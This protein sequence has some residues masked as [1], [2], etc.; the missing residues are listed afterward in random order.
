MAHYVAFLRGI[1][2]GGHKPVKMEE[3]CAL[4][5]SLGFSGVRTHIQSGNVFFDSSQKDEDALASVIRKKISKALGYDAA[6]FVRSVGSLRALLKNNP[7]R[8]VET[9]NDAKPYITFI[10]EKPPTGMKLPLFSPNKDVEIFAM[11]KGVMFSLSHPCKGRFGFPNAFIEK[12]LKAEAT[13]RNWETLG[14]M[15]ASS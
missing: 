13:T 5:L 10:P 14:E 15:M 9:G 6:V 7:F 4:V 12:T 1:N 3:L 8:N 11:G 2:V